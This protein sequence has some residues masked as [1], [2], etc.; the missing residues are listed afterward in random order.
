MRVQL[1]QG[2]VGRH[3]DQGDEFALVNGQTAL[4]EHLT[5]DEAAQNLFKIRES[6][7]KIRIDC[8]R[9][10]LAVPEQLSI[11]LFGPFNS[12]H[13]NLLLVAI[14]TSSREAAKSRSARPVTVSLMP[15]E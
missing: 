12:V 7:L 8:I 11:F 3:N 6:T 1:W 14:T 4:I 9:G 5:E 15:P 13:K 10:R 2:L